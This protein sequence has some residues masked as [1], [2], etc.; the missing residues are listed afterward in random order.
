MQDICIK[1]KALIE[2]HFFAHVCPARLRAFERSGSRNG[3]VR[4]K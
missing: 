1:P 2:M 4:R 3:V